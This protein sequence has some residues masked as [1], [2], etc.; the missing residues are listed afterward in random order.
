VDA[1]LSMIDPTLTSALMPFQRE[2]V[3]FGISR[4]GRV[5]IADDMVCKLHYH[6]NGV[7]FQIHTVLGIYYESRAWVKLFKH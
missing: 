7:V 4:G 2:G 5:L 6:I 3:K 1:D